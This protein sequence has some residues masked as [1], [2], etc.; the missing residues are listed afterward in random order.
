MIYD[1]SEILT[2]AK[3]LFVPTEWPYITSYL[4]TM[5]PKESKVLHVD[6]Q[7]AAFV[8]V[9]TEKGNAFISYCGVSSEHQGKGYGSKLLKETLSSIFQVDF[10]AA[11]LY[12]DC[13]NKDALRLYTRLGFKQIGVAHVA[14]S[15]CLLLELTRADYYDRTL[16]S[17]CIRT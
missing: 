13:W 10:P 4:E 14:G 16:T 2:L 3:K 11:R 17:A 8:I 5:L 7:L 15:D 9:N 1:K 6:G 12:V